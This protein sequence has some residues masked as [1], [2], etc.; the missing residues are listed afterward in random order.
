MA[1]KVNNSIHFWVINESNIFFSFRLKDEV[2]KN[3][4]IADYTGLGE[5]VVI[6][7]PGR[8][9]LSTVMAHSLKSKH[10]GRGSI[11]LNRVFPI[12]NNLKGQLQISEGYGET[13]MDYNH[14]QSTIGLSVSMVEW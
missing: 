8:H 10:G 2:D 13:L 9:Q 1:K 12:I 14:R 4:G 6:F 11:Q 7:N 5:A 3:P